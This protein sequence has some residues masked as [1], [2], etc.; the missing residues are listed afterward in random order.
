MNSDENKEPVGINIM[1]T[2]VCISTL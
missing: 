1:A 2:I